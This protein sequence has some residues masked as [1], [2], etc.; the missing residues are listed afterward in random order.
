MTKLSWKDKDEQAMK[1]R[2]R[3]VK[4]AATQQ[5]VPP[6]PMPA[7]AQKSPG[8]WHPRREAG[9]TTRR[10]GTPCSA[11]ME[12]S[13][14]TSKPW[15]RQHK[16]QK[17][18]L[19]GIFQNASAQ[20]DSLSE[21]VFAAEMTGENPPGVGTGPDV[22]PRLIFSVTPETYNKTQSIRNKIQ[23]LEAFLNDSDISIVCLTEH[24]LTN[25]E[26]ESL[27]VSGYTIASSFARQKLLKGGSLILAKSNINCTAINKVNKMSIERQC[28]ISCCYFKN[29][30]LHIP[31]NCD[32]ETE[33]HFTFLRILDDALSHLSNKNIIIAGDFNIKFGTNSRYCSAILDLLSTFGFQQMITENTRNDHCI[34]NIFINFNITS[35]IATVESK[36]CSDHLGQNI[37]FQPPKILPVSSAK[38]VCRPITEYGKFVFFNLVD[39]L[40]WDFIQDSSLNCDNKFELFIHKLQ[41]CLHEAFPEKN[42]PCRPDMTYN[43]NWFHDELRGMRE[44]LYFLNN[45]YKHSKSEYLKHT[46][47]EFRKTYKHAIITAKKNYNEQIIRRSSNPT[48]AMW[49]IVNRARKSSSLSIDQ[50][51]KDPNEFNNFFCSMSLRLTVSKIKEKRPKNLP[52]GK[53]SP[54]KQI[55]IPVNKPDD[56][57]D[58]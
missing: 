51:S 3:D 44:Y 43:S 39:K 5:T 31:V 6:T 25:N 36:F 30:D 40:N 33:D 56:R 38:I 18:P 27:N 19:C 7:A 26:I 42:L 46:L 2:Q 28:E 17:L 9:A 57:W 21:S 41:N 13:E 11:R 10:A 16:F 24:H 45:L 35:C 55:S 53:N 12:N 22:A 4:A 37:I 14:V 15:Q 23:E 47:N 29:Y 34:D 20:E 52:H 8:S 58:D 54:T 50:N 32:I 1:D 48:K 49:E